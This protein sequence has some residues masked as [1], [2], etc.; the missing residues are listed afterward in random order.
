MVDTENVG[1]LYWECVL[2]GANNHIKAFKLQDQR[3]LFTTGP[4]SYHM[5]LRRTL[6]ECSHTD[7][8]RKAY[9]HRP[10]LNP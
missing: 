4:Q 7:V 9:V 1:A 3:N 2:G 10:C 8:V 5:H 6:H